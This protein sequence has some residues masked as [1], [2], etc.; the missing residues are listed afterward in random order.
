MVMYGMCYI[1]IFMCSFTQ[2]N[3]QGGEE[4]N[5]VHTNHSVIYLTH[6]YELPDKSDDATLR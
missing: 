4:Q 6:F 5:P 3:I 2:L 1:S